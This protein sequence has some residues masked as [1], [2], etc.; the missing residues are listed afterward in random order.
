MESLESPS[1]HKINFLWERL[2]AAKSSVTV[3][4]RSH[5]QYHLFFPDNSVY[6]FDTSIC[7]TN[8]FY[9]IVCSSLKFFPDNLTDLSR[10]YRFLFFGK[11]FP[12]SFIY[13]RLISITS[14]IRTFTEFFNYVIVQVN[15]NSSLTFLLNYLSSF[16]FAKIIFLFHN[17]FSLLELPYGLKSIELCHYDMYIQ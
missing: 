13:H 17:I 12:E 15:G 1:C 6:F 3:I 16:A 7:F 5:F 9:L 2:L 11:V 8:A 4:N 14:G 10:C